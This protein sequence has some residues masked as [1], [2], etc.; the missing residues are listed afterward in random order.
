MA[1]FALII[2][3]T[4]TACSKDSPTDPNAS[5]AGAYTLRTVN[6]NNLPFTVLQVGADKAEVL[7]E[8]ITVSDAG[9]FTQQGTFR[10]TESGVVTTEGYADAGTYTRS[11]TAVTFVFLSDGSSGTGTVSGGVITVGFEGFSYVYRK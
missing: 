5:I 10:F 11:G 2:V 4:V 1:I 9:T 6:G 8:T 7:N 3:A